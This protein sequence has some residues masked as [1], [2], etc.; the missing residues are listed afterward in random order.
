LSGVIG[1]NAAPIIIDVTKV[2]VGD[3]RQSN[4]AIVILGERIFEKLSGLSSPHLPVA[5]RNEP[6]F[7]LESGETL[8]RRPITGKC[9]EIA[10]AQRLGGAEL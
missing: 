3:Q 10:H 5:P 1:H 8:P 7:P 4:M 9:V 6:A 2:L